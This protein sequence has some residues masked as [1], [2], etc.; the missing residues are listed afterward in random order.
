MAEMLFKTERFILFRIIT[1][2]V[3]MKNKIS[4][5]IIDKIRLENKK[6]YSKEEIFKIIKDYE[7]IYKRKVNLTSL[8]TYLRKD[9][10]VK[11]ILGDYYYAYSLEE[12]HN[13]YCHFSEEELIFLVLEKMKAKWYLGLERALIENKVSWQAINFA[14]I[15]NSRFSGFKKLGNSKFKFIKTREKRLNFGLIGK[16]TNNGVKYFY[17]DI[18][19]TYLDFLYFYSYEGKDIRIIKKNL[20]FKVNKYRLRKYAK[21]YSKRVLEAV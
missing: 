18:E 20:D 19:K 10:Y 8:W 14:P 17:S 1:K 5:K 13:Q 12:R 7:R 16:K 6:I 9:K 2:T 15:I 3:I 21:S 4:R 11:R